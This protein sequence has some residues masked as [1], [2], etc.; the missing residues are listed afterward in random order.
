MHHKDKPDLENYK[1]IYYG[2]GKDNRYE[3]PKTGAHFDFLDMCKRL[4]K[5]Q[6]K[7]EAAE[8]LIP[9]KTI[10]NKDRLML[11]T[12]GRNTRA[13]QYQTFDCVKP[14]PTKIPPKV[15]VVDP[16]C[17]Y[18]QTEEVLNGLEYTLGNKENKGKSKLLEQALDKQR[19][20]F[21]TLK[22]CE[23]GQTI[24]KYDSKIPVVTQCANMMSKLRSRNGTASGY[25]TDA[26][27]MHKGTFMNASIIPKKTIVNE[28]GS[29]S[30]IQTNMVN[31]KYYKKENTK[32]APVCIELMGKM[33]T[34]SGIAGIKRKESIEKV[35]R[36]PSRGLIV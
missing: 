36:A 6:Q 11:G 10:T 9:T 1:G 23:S 8:S 18:K 13:K 20:T 4:S 32:A 35:K 22:T 25:R 5:I 21:T 31:S 15:L 28:Q 24:K 7:R 17:E 3:D 27:G 30:I 33:K 12:D 26:S 34:G 14:V 19:N 29:K 16:I 2:D